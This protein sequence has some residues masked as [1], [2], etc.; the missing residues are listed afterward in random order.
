LTAVTDRL[1]EVFS[2]KVLRLTLDGS[3]E[4]PSRS[5]PLKREYCLTE[6]ALQE[7]EYRRFKVGASQHF[8]TWRRS[9]DRELSTPLAG[10]RIRE[11]RGIGHC[12]PFIVGQRSG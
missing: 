11:C 9:T 6:S 4:S 10:N 1:L 7:I 2:N 12:R 3:L 8:R 5:N